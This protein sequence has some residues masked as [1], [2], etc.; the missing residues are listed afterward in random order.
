MLD[1]SNLNAMKT[2]GCSDGYI[3]ILTDG[4]LILIFSN[5][6]ECHSAIHNSAMVPIAYFLFIVLVILASSSVLARNQRECT[7]CANADFL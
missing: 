5:E 2:N 7:V 3:K 6:I 4:R 1:K